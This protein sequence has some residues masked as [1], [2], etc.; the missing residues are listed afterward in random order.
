MI[1]KMMSIEADSV[2]AGFVADSCIADIVHYEKL[3][4]GHKHLVLRVAE[5]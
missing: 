4:V 1:E 5:V 2:I 3:G